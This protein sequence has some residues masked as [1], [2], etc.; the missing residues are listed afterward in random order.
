MAPT[1]LDTVRAMYDSRA[2][3]YDQESN[4][5]ARQAADYIT[6]MKL[7][8]GL[9]VLDLACGTGLL[10]IAAAQ[11]VGPTGTVIG[12]D[13]SPVS[14]DL[15]KEKAKKEGLSVTFLEHDIS[16]L[17]GLEAEGITEGT[18]DVI[19]CA[20]AVVLLE[21]PSA[22]VKNWTKWLKKGGRI[23]F[24]APTDDSMVAG[25]CLDRT[26]EKMGIAITGGSR[27][28]LGTAASVTQLLKGAG[29]DSS[30]SF[31][32]GEY[33]PIEELDA[34]KAGA[35]FDA[36]V[37]DESLRQKED[38]GKKWFA[39][40]FEELAVPEVRQEAKDIFCREMEALANENGKVQSHVRFNIAIG[41]KI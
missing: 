9:K 24:D 4:F 17:Y 14:L 6:W 12:V 2:A 7:T 39:R 18:F 25:V 8:P 26:K 30:E 40:W 15:A 35:I 19:S 32:T 11:A 1:R 20:S 21:D 28:H 5:H 27:T 31:L 23:I 16:S 41:R 33:K 13:I 38:E 3:G 29:L 36:H 10:T 22:A 37:G 34:A